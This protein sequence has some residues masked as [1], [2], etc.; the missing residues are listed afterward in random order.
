M[1]RFRRLRGFWAVVAL[2]V[3]LGVA[4]GQELTPLLRPSKPMVEAAQRHYLDGARFF[5]AGQFDAALVE[6]EASY[7]L[8]GERDLLHNLSWTHEKAGRVRE[9]LGY[10]ER[11]LQ[12]CEGSG[13]DAERARR[14]VEFLRRTY[15]TTQTGQ[16]EPV[17]AKPAPIAPQQSVQTK[18]ETPKP[19]TAQPIASVPR[20]D[21]YLAV[22]P[23]DTVTA[24]KVANMR[25]AISE[26]KV[27]EPNAT[28]RGLKPRAS[29]GIAAMALGAAALVA[30]VGL[31]ASTQIDRNALLS[32]TLNYSAAQDVASRANATRT[33]A[34]SLGIVGG[35][36]TLSGLPLV[37]VSSR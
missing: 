28:K 24:Q 8:S 25:S 35:V 26:P 12:A 27:V 13:D 22:R 14:R 10:A 11:Y 7:K 6:F 32:G 31:G 36:L 1:P 19:E 29:L 17:G 30:T 5:E 15:P 33:A 18:P 3:F 2:G 4:S 16:P 34:I 9:A 20:A 21:R 37:I 23:D